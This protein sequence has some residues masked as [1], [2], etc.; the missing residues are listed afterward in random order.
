MITEDDVSVDRVFPTK[1]DGITKAFVS[2]RVGPIVIKGFRIV[3][4]ISKETGDE[5]T[6]VGNPSQPNKDGKFFDTIFFDDEDFNKGL[7][8]KVM[9]AWYE[10]AKQRQGGGTQS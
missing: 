2:V 1:G 8:R 9:K 3:T 5:Y 10:V 4:T 7:K 6:F